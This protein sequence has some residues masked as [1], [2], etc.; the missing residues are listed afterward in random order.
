MKRRRTDSR[1]ELLPRGIVYS[2][3]IKLV[4]R[5]TEGGGERTIL[6]R[7]QDR[8]PHLGSRGVWDKLK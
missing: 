8:S 4:G 5:R 3:P 6:V 2:Y 7:D 1:H